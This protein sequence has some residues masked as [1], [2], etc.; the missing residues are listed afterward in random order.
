MMRDRESI[1]TDI[2]ETP[3]TDSQRLCELAK[4]LDAFET[5]AVL[6]CE[7]VAYRV[8]VESFLRGMVN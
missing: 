7:D 6:L 4:E 1:L 8:W 3:F 5:E 2:A